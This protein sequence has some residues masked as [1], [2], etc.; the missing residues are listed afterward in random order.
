MTSSTRITISIIGIILA[1]ALVGLL[2]SFRSRTGN[3]N[4][5]VN[6]PPQEITQAF[7]QAT[8]TFGV[9]SSTAPAPAPIPPTKRWDVSV[10][11]LRHVGFTPPKGYWVYFSESDL[12]YWLVKGSPPKA[13]SPD[14]VASALKNRVAIIHTITWDHDSFPTWD[15]FVTTMAQFDCAEG[16]TSENLI[17]CLDVHRNETNGKTV[18]GLLMESFSLKAVLQVGQA[19]KGLRAFVVVRLGPQNDDGLLIT[20]TDQSAAGAASALAKTMRIVGQ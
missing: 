10:I 13:G 12:S 20:L 8:S 18:A 15:R 7:Q 2:L 17:T 16:T 11:E 1:A 9:A 19:P 5:S 3:G 4:A 14:P 6:P